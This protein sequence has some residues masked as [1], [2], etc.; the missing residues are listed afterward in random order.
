MKIPFEVDTEEEAALSMILMQL[1]AEKQ[2]LEEAL[3]ELTQQKVV[4]EK[5]ARASKKAIEDLETQERD[6]LYAKLNKL[7][8]DDRR[9]RRSYEEMCVAHSALLNT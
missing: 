6:D 3:K 5:E 8:E 4:L 1:A 2:G 7:K 9:L